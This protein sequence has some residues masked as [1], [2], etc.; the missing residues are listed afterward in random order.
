MNTLTKIFLLNEKIP[1]AARIYTEHKEGVM[2][3]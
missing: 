1:E 3:G 2:C